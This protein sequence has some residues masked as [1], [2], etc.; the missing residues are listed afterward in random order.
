M[1]ITQLHVES[2][3]LTRQSDFSGVIVLSFLQILS[4][5]NIVEFSKK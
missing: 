3:R 2:D 5:I 4:H 1:L